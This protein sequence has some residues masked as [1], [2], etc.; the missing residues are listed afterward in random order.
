LR[1]AD[2]AAGRRDFVEAVRWIETVRGV[3]ESL[4]DEYEAKCRAWVEALGEVAPGHA[5]QRD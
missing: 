1:W 5:A 2:E 3:G 4:P